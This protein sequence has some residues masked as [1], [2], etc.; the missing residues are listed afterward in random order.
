MKR[1]PDG[2]F[3]CVSEKTVTVTFNGCFYIQ[4]PDRSGGIRVVPGY[5]LPPEGLRPGHLISFTGEMGVVDGERVV[6]SNSEFVSDDQT[7]AEIAPFGT[8]SPTI[9]GWPVDYLDLEGP[10][11]TGLV[12]VGLLVKIW[13]EVT[14]KQVLDEEGFWHVYLDDGW[15][16]KD[17]SYGDYEGVRVYSDRIPP[18]GED[19]QV[20]LGVCSTKTYDP[21]PGGAVGDEFII[22]VVRTT[23]QDA[24]YFP[25]APP[26]DP[27]Y[28]SISG[29]VFLA[30]QMEPGV[31]VRVYSE[32][33]SVTVEDVTETGKSFTLDWVPLNG[34]KVCASAPGYLSSTQDAAGGDSGLLFT[35][36]PTGSYMEIRCDKESI[37]ICSEET[38]TV[39]AL[40]RDCEG[41]GL[42]GRQVEMTTTMGNFLGSGAHQVVVM[43]DQDG[44]ALATLTAGSDGKGIA[45]VTARRY[46]GGTPGAQTAVE[47]TG[48]Q[49]TMSAAPGHLS[50]PGDSLIQAQLSDSGQPVV[51]GAVT[52]ATQLG[53]F[54]ESGGT[55][56]TTL[57]NGSGVAECHLTLGAPGAAVVVAKYANACAQETVNWVTVA[58]TQDPWYSSGVGSS[59]PLV[60]DMDGA[61]DGNKEVVVVTSAGDLSVI[62]LGGSL[63]WSK[64]LHPPG[65]NTPACAVLDVTRTGL[66]SIFVPAESQQKV[67]AYTHDGQQLAGWPVGSNYRF[68]KVSAAIADANLDGSLEIIGGDECCYVFTWNPT[69]D[70]Q[71]NGTAESSYLWRNLTGTPSTAIYGSSCAVGDVSPDPDGILDVFVGT[72][73]PSQVYGFPGDAWGDYITSPLYLDGWPKAAVSH[74]ESSPAIGDID[75]DG[76][77]DVTVGSDDGYLY[78]WLSDTDSW[79]AL[80]TGGAVKS[81]PALC[82]LD[83]D[84]RLDVVVGSSSG[85]VF[86]FNWL[87][88]AVSGWAGGVLLNQTD[89][90]PVESS[91]VVGDITG[92]GDLNVVVGCSDGNVYALYSD[93]MNHVEDEERTGPI[94]WIGCCIPQSE[95][96]AEIVAA[97]VIDDLDNDGDVDLVVAGSR[98]IYLFDLAA[99]YTCNPVT[100]PWPTFHH[101]NQRTG[102]A[103]E[104]PEPVNASIQGIVTLNGEP[105]AGAEVRIYHNDGSLVY[106]PHSDPP[107][108]R[109][110][111]KT[112]GATGG[113][114]R[115][116][117]AYCI[118]QLEPNQ[119]YK[120]EVSYASSVTWVTD[121]AV[122][123][124]LVRVDVSL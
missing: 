116:A 69:G 22:P 80:P 94:A 105:V 113:T 71:A 29:T 97:P 2:A 82:D 17:G 34:A 75:G 60:V 6:I 61:P 46:S 89:E 26:Q 123:T 111:V 56:Y 39:I 11:H 121:I 106:E 67:Y 62:D 25:S 48:A 78:M 110:F 10:R 112:V 109:D 87:G 24:L 122:T 91:P 70:W 30:G 68:I 114:G 77:N 57:T 31:D 79:I 27:T 98:G 76:S 88:Q 86:A 33:G 51:G 107:V 23:S 96:E 8:A 5:S 35:L 64:A 95:T 81:S 72:N 42:P 65:S 59:N 47:F 55:V 20:A 84:G 66:P 12:P 43:T 108:T 117:G 19:F 74:V 99:P 45:E 52:F 83:G 101:D 16:M 28:D 92:D 18:D 3:V 58:Y 102:C 40:L 90:F 115:G 104:A 9:M 7:A 54:Q 53:V 50:S 37:R 118:N 21:T 14:A 15:S 119:I 49:I 38:A 44:F 32:R 73:H 63:L 1:L 100:C 85:R 103:A 4:E 36:Q 13:G 120:I 93:G 41:K 124:G